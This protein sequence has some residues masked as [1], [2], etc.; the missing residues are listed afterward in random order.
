[1][2]GKTAKRR[3][4]ELRASSSLPR[5]HH[6]FL[7]DHDEHHPDGDMDFEN[8]HRPMRLSWDEVF[9]ED[10]LGMGGFGSVCLVTCPKLRKQREREERKAASKENGMNSSMYDGNDGNDSMNAS[11][12]MDD[13]TFGGSM[14][15]SYASSTT[16]TGYHTILD[17]NKYYA[18]KSLS[19]KTIKQ[20][21]IRGFVQAA[22]DLVNEAFLLSHITPHPNLV[23]LYGIPRGIIESAF[24]CQSDASG[25]DLGYF[26]ILEALGG[27]ILSDKVSDWKQKQANLLLEQNILRKRREQQQQKRNA[28]LNSFLGS[29]EEQRKSHTGR[30]NSEASG[31]RGTSNGSEETEHVENINTTGNPSL[32]QIPT[33][34]ERLE[35]ALQIASGMQHLHAHG[36]VFRDLKPHN[37]GLSISFGPPNSNNND[38]SDTLSSP[39][40]PPQPTHFTWRLFDFG[41]A[42][43]V[44]KS[45]YSS[46]ANSLRT[47]MMGGVGVEN[48]Q[49]HVHHSEYQSKFNNNHNNFS[50]GYNQSVAA[51]TTATDPSVCYGKAGSLRYMAPE[52]MGG[53]WLRSSKHQNSVC[54]ATFG[55]DV[56]AF[57]IVL[58]ELVGLTHFEK[59]YDNNAEEFESAVCDRGHRPSMEA[60]DRAIEADVD[61]PDDSPSKL[62][63]RKCRHSN[64]RELVHACWREDYR[65][66][67]NFDFIVNA[68]R[69]MLSNHSDVNIEGEE[70]DDDDG[71]DLD[72]S[73]VATDN[74]LNESELDFSSNL[75]DQHPPFQ[76]ELPSYAQHQQALSRT[77]SHSYTSGSGR[78]R[79]RL[80]RKM[81][82]RTLSSRS[83]LS[84]ASMSNNSMI[85][86][87]VF[88]AETEHSGS[89]GSNPSSSHH[90]TSNHSNQKESLDD[91]DVE[92]DSDG[93]ESMVNEYSMA[94]D[95]IMNESVI[96]ISNRKHSSS[97]YIEYCA[98][99][100]DDKAEF[101]YD[102]HEKIEAIDNQ[103]STPASPRVANADN[104][105]EE[106]LHGDKSRPGKKKKKD[107]TSKK[108]RKTKSRK[109]SV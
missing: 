61:L 1:M 75:Q 33:I 102:P 98:E 25:S 93:D 18:C 97:R 6:D 70:E 46:I 73:T 99:S 8:L 31:S 45:A 34:E 100:N 76:Q 36:I 4:N 85:L 56:Y 20:A 78:S 87:D 79:R 37:V 103:Y 2:A 107:K 24:D 104:G 35:I 83:M 13:S 48:Y 109:D 101:R 29:P 60:L 66:R 50:Y 62:A 81:S 92:E 43:E 52:T 10:L 41:L 39:P 26:L 89:G 3:L 106:E 95:S 64:I 22:A 14:M 21:N 67:P 40:S 65:Q 90:K 88:E 57:A 17:T 9:V 82:A 30:R 11:F 27:G 47:T 80:M 105:S 44:P 77:S 49:K 28:S 51:A 108:S 38:A 91:S 68:L 53:R 74:I 69:E 86:E 42:R 94:N 63:A 54:F 59:K 23:R 96:T 32:Y 19:N 55:S 16:A 7:S 12:A 71:E 58:W 72:A 84:Q 15:L 5:A